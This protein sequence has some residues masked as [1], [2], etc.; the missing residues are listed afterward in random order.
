M[1]FD[2]PNSLVEIK[3]NSSWWV[4]VRFFDIPISE[5]ASCMLATGGVALWHMTSH[6]CTEVATGVLLTVPFKIV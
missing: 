6:G 4:Q 3:F 5:N 1:H 2:T